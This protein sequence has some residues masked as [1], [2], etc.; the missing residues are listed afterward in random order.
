M[1][2]IVSPNTPI[3]E[4]QLL[5]NGRYHVMVTNAGGGSSRWKDLAVT[6]W[7]E[8][9]TCDNWGTFC[10]I[11]DV[12]SGDFWSA[13]H[14]P[15][16]RRSAHYEAIFTEARAEFRRRD[17]DLESHT[18]IVVSPEDDIEL[19]RL[20]ITN[21]SRTRRTIDV[22]SYAEVALSSP[23]ADALHPAFSNL[24]VQTEIVPQ[25][26]AILCTRRPRSQDEQAPWMFHLMAV[27][28]AESLEVSYETDRAAFI[29]RGRTVAA[30]QAMTGA[31]R[32]SDTQG[33]VLDPIVAIR[34]RVTLDPQQTATFDIVSGVAETRDAALGLVGKYQDRHLADRVFDLAW[35]HS[36]VTLRQINATES[37]A[38]LYARLASSVIYANA[39][40]RAEAGVLLRNRRGQSGL[41]SYAISGDLPIVLLQIGD[42]EN[43][44][45]VRRMVQA[46]AYWRLKGLAVDLVIWNEDRGGYRQVLQDQIMGLIAAGVEA[47]VMDRPGGI[48]V[49]RAEQIS[50]E[51]R[52]L[53]QTVARAII[54]DRRGSL[55]EQ[56]ARRGPT[57]VRV[58]RL[59]PTA[60]R[61][62]DTLP[63]EPAARDLILCNGLGGFTPDG[64]E[65]VITLGPGQAT[66]APWANVLAN[67]HFGTVISESGLAY[68]WSENAH[69]FR[70]T[71]WHNDPVSDASGEALFLRDEETGHF[72]SPAPLPC[73][74]AGT[75]VTRH[76]FGYSVF[77]HDEDG[78]RSELWVYVAID[79]AVKF[80]VLK[81]RNTSGRPRRL[82]ATA[83][84]EWVLG[85][86]RPKT[87]MHVVTEVSPKHGA[88]L[89]RNSY[90]TE[91]PDR[92]AF[93][94]VDDATRSVSGDRTE[95][96]GRNG[97]LR[98]PAAMARSRLS[99]KV[100]AALDPCGAIQVP[101]ELADG[102][103]REI[104]FR[105]GVGRDAAQAGSLVER[106]RGPSAARGAL[107]AVRAHWKRT[108]GAVQV[109][110]PDAA[111][112][113]L[114]N[115]WLLYQTVACRLWARSG[116]YQSGG[117]F[118]FRDQL[119]DAMALVHAEPALLRE[120][121]LRCAGRQFVEGDVQHW[122]HP[123]SGRGVR[124]R[125]SDDYLW[126]P[127]ATARYVKATGDTGVLD[128]PVQF[129]EGRPVNPGDD[130][131]YD[132]PGRS[133]E[134]ASLYEHCVRAIV[135]GLRYGAHGLPLMGSGDW[136]DGMNLVGIKGAGESVWL[137]FFLCAVLK[138][139]GGIAKPAGDPAFADRCETEVTSASP[140]SRAARLG[141][142]MVPA[143]VLRRRI[144][145]GIGDQRGLPHRLRVAELVGAVG[146]GR[147]RRARG[148]P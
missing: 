8:D 113:V 86:L 36:W 141:R 80:S 144:A 3:P 69:E 27:H 10:Y 2:V 110:T 99:G 56:V 62:S 71:P 82:S 9:S 88:L 90:N 78:I 70:L 40:L 111:L 57:E 41:W 81:V 22:T 123:P 35:T 117:A 85:D 50:D 24:F 109:A 32:L 72:W 54:T 30:P 37:D 98:H 11:R 17:N 83:Y 48:F 4:V 21:R 101:F 142:R 139:F 143:R 15:T 145:A 126:L 118:G 137:G 66:P 116:Y 115:G 76:G 33:S 34:H 107:D 28:G 104:V 134:S 130:S 64:S 138:Q 60:S 125:C 65:Y 147:R 77:E 16:P 13:A 53:L 68:T 29:G 7:R 129:L 131:Y 51:D 49:R 58:P 89:A 61:R 14:Q 63:A 122:W 1:R 47:H 120:Q 73:R 18:E 95:F 135:H 132:L 133:A 31:D 5:S 55:V 87:A 45:L 127:F 140:E 52:I 67:P 46:H 94:D 12:A 93:F 6:R 39:S 59:V 92:V 114:A 91:F 148:W 84:V 119:Q 75:Y 112:D 44:D 23:A 25:R 100:G 105:L 26:Q 121:L 43:I 106:F 38:Q 42:S 79:A 19:R 20:R 108:L 103:E 146:R 124:T 97:T 136:N 102:Q 128:E 74:G 96:L